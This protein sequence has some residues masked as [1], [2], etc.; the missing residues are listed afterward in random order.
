[1]EGTEKTRFGANSRIG[2]TF[3]SVFFFFRFVRNVFRIAI[4]RRLQVDTKWN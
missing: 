4:N 2:R 3:S 1:M